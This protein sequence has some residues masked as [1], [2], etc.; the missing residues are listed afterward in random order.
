M[1]QKEKNSGVIP[2]PAPFQM[3]KS[4]KKPFKD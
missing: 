4:I 3:A 1:Y 2:S